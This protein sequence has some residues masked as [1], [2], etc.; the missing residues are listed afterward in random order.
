MERSAEQ[1]DGGPNPTDKEI[2]CQ[3]EEFC[4]VGGMSEAS[5][6]SVSDMRDGGYWLLDKALGAWRREAA[7]LFPSEEQSDFGVLEVGAHHAV[8]HSAEVQNKLETLAGDSAAGSTT[9]E[10]EIKEPSYG[11]SLP[12]MSADPAPAEVGTDPGGWS[13]RLGPGGTQDAGGSAASRDAGLKGP[14]PAA[15]GS[16]A[17]VTASQRKK[18]KKGSKHRPA[19]WHAEEIKAAKARLAQEMSGEG[20]LSQE[21][22]AR[23][24]SA[25]GRGEVATPTSE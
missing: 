3:A 4:R 15:G 20:S 17:E 14:G 19:S 25:P 13:P 10:R 6:S 24:K 22:A 9:L 21:Q 2:E 11:A 16:E 7:A 12:E 18:R 23:V 8:K 5:S 1:K